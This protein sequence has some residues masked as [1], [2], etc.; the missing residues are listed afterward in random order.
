V[1]VVEVARRPGDAVVPFDGVGHALHVDRVDRFR[2]DVPAAQRFQRGGALQEKELVLLDDRR[3]Q[4]LGREELV[5]RDAERLGELDEEKGM[6]GALATDRILAALLD[7]QGDEGAL[8][9]EV[10][11][12]WRVAAD[13]DDLPRG[14]TEGVEEKAS[15][16]PDDALEL[17]PVER[18][19]P[20][21]EEERM[22]EPGVCL[23]RLSEECV[24]E[25][26]GRERHR[27]APCQAAV[28]RRSNRWANRDIA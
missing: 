16:L 11:E 13:R 12:G 2:G 22:V 24:R 1:H 20:D 8:A 25:L 23:L 28:S 26:R 9:L 4:V 21:Q 3:R 10:L 17:A 14:V 6:G 15:L 7:D 27:R 5:L 19:V 18:A